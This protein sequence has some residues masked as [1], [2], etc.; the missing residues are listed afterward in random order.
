MR[1]ARTAGVSLLAL[2]DHDTMDGIAEA[3]TAAQATCVRLIPGVEISANWGGRTVHILGLGVDP[4]APEL[5]GGLARLQAY[6]LWR[7]EEIGRLLARAGI[8]G[9]LE[10]ARSIAKGRLV[11]RTHFARFLVQGGY[12][13]T[14]RDVFKHYLVKGKPGHV[15]GEWA[16]MEETVAWIR[17]AGGQAV[18]AHP[19]RYRFTRSKMLRMIREFRE[20]GGEGLE[21]ISGSHSRDEIHVFARHAREQGMLASAG[22]DFHG[23]DNPYLDVGRLPSLPAGCR[24]IWEAWD[25]QRPVPAAST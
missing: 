25:L 10:G 20:Q 15:K 22:S 2:T 3:R 18:I 12:A 1:R 16:R 7:A 11:A 5:A 6:R 21:V 13:Q 24:P 9:A 8:I 19:G 14:V 23:P 4:S 17:G